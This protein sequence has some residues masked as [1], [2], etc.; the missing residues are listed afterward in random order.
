MTAH[1]VVTRID[2]AVAGHYLA[3]VA[4]GDEQGAAAFVDGL[5][6]DGVPAQR[7]IVD[8]IGATQI[9]V[10]EL[11]A[12]NEWSVAREHAATAAAE[13]ALATIAARTP[14]PAS[15]AFPGRTRAPATVAAPPARG[16]IT[17]ACVDGEWHGLPARMLAEL[18]RLDG[19]RVDY[20]GASV[21]GR[22]LITHLHQTGPDAVALSCMIP[23]RLPRAHAA[24]T[25]CRAAGVPVIAGGRGFGPG[26]RWAQPLGAQAWAATG[27]D[28]VTRLATDWPPPYVAGPLYSP[29]EPLSADEEYTHLTRRRPELITTSMQRLAASYPAAHHYDQSQAESTAEDL[30]HLVDFLAAALYVGEP[31]IFLDFTQWTTEV[32][33]ARDVPPNALRAGLR[34]IRDQLIDFPSSVNLLD[35]ALTKIPQP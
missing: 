33:R 7:L 28:A 2:D 1:Q 11:W 21:P 12:A 29:A 15:P 27:E 3:L 22:H 9:R 5:L 18:L 20:L 13:R 19:W 26:G 23:T 32:L 6:D 17:L 31:T 14:A 10:G 4:D 30:G 25:A 35:T 8:L 16:R 24:I 34:L